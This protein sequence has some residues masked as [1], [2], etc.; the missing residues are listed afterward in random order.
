M[1]QALRL[2]RASMRESAAAASGARVINNQTAATSSASTGSARALFALGRGVNIDAGG[3]P[4]VVGGSVLEEKRR[5]AQG[6]ALGVSSVRL[7]E[8]L[9]RLHGLVVD[10]G[11]HCLVF[12]VGLGV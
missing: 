8:D 4:A 11:D 6:V 5:L 3:G 12:V 9:S 10:P 1:R 7:S 2:R